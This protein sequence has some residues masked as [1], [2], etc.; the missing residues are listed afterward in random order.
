MCHNALGTVG[1]SNLL[2]NFPPFCL[3]Y[4][5]VVELE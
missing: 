5:Y 2:I 3:R 1:L 4:S